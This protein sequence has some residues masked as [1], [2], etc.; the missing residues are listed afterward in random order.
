MKASK[1]NIFDIGLT[2]WTAFIVILQYLL[3]FLLFLYV[4]FRRSS[5]CCCCCC[6][7]LLFILHQPPT[8][9]LIHLPQYCT[10]NFEVPLPQPSKG[11]I[12]V[13]AQAVTTHY[14]NKNI[15]ILYCNTTV[16]SS[17]YHCIVCYR[18]YFPHPGFP[19]FPKS[20]LSTTR[21]KI[22]AQ[23]QQKNYC[24]MI[25]IILVSIAPN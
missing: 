20:S 22:Q 13:T 11:G 2:P 7:C 17:Y 1:R 8:A 12:V 4:A 23:Q 24:M 3:L 25:S 18:A 15:I 16:D 14:T 9:V 21:T 6:C 5:K 10:S 19:G